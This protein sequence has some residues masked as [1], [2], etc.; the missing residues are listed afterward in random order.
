MVVYFSVLIKLMHKD[1]PISFIFPSANKNI[2]QFF[3]LK[4]KN[5]AP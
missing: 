4:N 3:L 1:K 5:R 2:F